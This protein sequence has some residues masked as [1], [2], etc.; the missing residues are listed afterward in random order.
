MSS[1]AQTATADT[2]ER[3]YYKEEEAAHILRMS[4]RSLWDE[5]KRGKIRCVRRGVRWKRYHRDEIRRYA[6]SLKSNQT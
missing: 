5:E 1:E 4:K 3:I 2:P 6:E